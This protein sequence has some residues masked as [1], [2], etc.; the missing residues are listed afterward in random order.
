MQLLLT[1]A[2]PSNIGQ[3]GDTI[4]QTQTRAR[5]EISGNCAQTG[6]VRDFSPVPHAELLNDKELAGYH[7]TDHMTNFLWKSVLLG[8]AE[9]P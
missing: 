5:M 8:S 2:A 1:S 3:D 9:P 7:R 6:R 4:I